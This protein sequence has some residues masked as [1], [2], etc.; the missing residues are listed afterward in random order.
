MNMRHLGNAVEGFFSFKERVKRFWKRFPFNSSFV[1]VQSW[2]ESFMAII[3]GGVYL[4][5]P[6]RHSLVLKARRRGE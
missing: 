3:T 5:S 2:I 1:S 4:D 6:A